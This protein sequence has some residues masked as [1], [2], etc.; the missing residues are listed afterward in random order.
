MSR[1][2]KAFE[3]DTGYNVIVTGRNV[4]VTEAMKGY[5]IEKVSKLERFANRIIDVIVTMDIQKLE[6]RVDIV[7]TVTHT[8]IKSR[9]SSENMYASIDKAVD[10]MHSQLQ[11]YKTRLQDHHAKG[12]AVVDMKV[13]VLRGPIDEVT[14][15]NDEIEEEN[16]KALEQSYKLHEIVA[17]ETMPLKILTYDEAVMKMELANDEP[18]MIFRHEQDQKI[19]VIY[20]RKDGNYGIIEP[21]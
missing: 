5:A 14:E 7:M 3:L 6:H 18:F 17:E 16:S 8:L 20:R 12:L 13:N 9:A 21:E 4:Q 15:V 2:E 19:K 10:K 11:K 1:K